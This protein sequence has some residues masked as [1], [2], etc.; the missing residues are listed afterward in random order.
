ME[1]RQRQSREMLQGLAREAR[2]APTLA[3]RRLWELLRD[4]RCGGLHFR[5]QDIIGPFRV[6]F[7]C[8]RLKL[9]IEVDG[10]I[11]EQE[12]VQR[13]DAGR[14]QIL[15]ADFG[16]QFL[17]V[18]NEDVL[19]RPQNVV[20]SIQALTDLEPESPHPCPSP[21]AGEE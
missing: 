1:G 9:V 8:R 20:A 12:D 19:Q 15:E 3:E 11:H 10:S 17:R 14:Q 5:R 4:H 13:H 16:I 6:D 21:E 2:R 18:T 7:F